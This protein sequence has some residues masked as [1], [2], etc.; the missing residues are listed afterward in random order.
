MGSVMPI[1]KRSRLLKWAHDRDGLIIEDDYDSELRSSVFP[2]SLQG[3]MG[4]PGGLPGF[5]SKI[6]LPYPDQLW[7]CL[8]ILWRI[9]GEK[10]PAIIR[11]LQIRANSLAL[12]KGGLL[13]SI[14]EGQE[15]IRPEESDAD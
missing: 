11:L 3:W 7:F 12:F 2:P 9:T 10:K 5:F 1:A 13:E 8:P 15:N 4:V 6:L 14:S